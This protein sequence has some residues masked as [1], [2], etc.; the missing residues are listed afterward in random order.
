MPDGR[1]AGVEG[2]GL[3][4]RLDLHALSIFTRS[5]FPDVVAG[6]DIGLDLHLNSPFG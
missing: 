2:T 1:D 4:V 5:P 6:L 3:E